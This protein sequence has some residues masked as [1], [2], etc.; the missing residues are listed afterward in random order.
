MKYGDCESLYC[1]FNAK[2]IGKTSLRN[3]CQNRFLRKAIVL[4]AKNPLKI[5]VY[6]YIVIRRFCLQTSSLD[7]LN[8]LLMEGFTIY[9]LC[10][11]YKP[12][13]NT[14]YIYLFIIIA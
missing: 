13:L 6:T 12:L 2:I 7:N 11:L 14:I 9:C 3:E 5:P 4:A 8:F 1:Y 10:V